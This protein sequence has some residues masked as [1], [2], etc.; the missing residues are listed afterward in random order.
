MPRAKRAL[1]DLGIYHVF[2]RGN[3]GLDIFNDSDDFCMF[4]RLL[5]ESKNEFNVQIFHYCLMRNH[6]HL[7][8]Q[9]P[10]WD[11]L[12]KFMHKIQ[13]T[14]AR[15][16]KKKL[17]FTGHLFQ[18]RYRSPLIP[19]ESYYLECGRYIERNPIKAGLVSDP[20]QYKWSS[21]KYYTRGLSDPIVTPNSYYL[22]IGQTPE[23]RKIQYQ[24]FLLIDDP[25]KNSW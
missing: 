11:T 20:S 22:E 10:H 13:L 23:E 9:I 15:F 21:A 16:F 5:N 24:K 12:P 1:L 4:S 19:E 8:L 3:N 6:F 25:Y 18:N 2:N 7:L 14:Y 17:D